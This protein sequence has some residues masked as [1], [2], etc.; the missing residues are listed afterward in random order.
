M[1]SARAHVAVVLD[2]DRRPVGYVT[3]EMLEGA[4]GAAADVAQPLPATVPARAD[5][6]AVVSEM[7]ANDVMWLVAVDDHGRFA[8]LV[9]QTAVTRALGETY[10]AG[11]AA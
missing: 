1:S 11:A 9:T 5:L 2:G 4:S 10:R 3:Q 6:R 8:G 7:F